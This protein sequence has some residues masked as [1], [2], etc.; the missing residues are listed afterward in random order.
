[1]LAKRK[2]VIVAF[3]L[4][5]GVVL[6]VGTRESEVDAHRRALH[7]FQVEQSLWGQL[8][9]EA[10][11]WL[12]I[13]R[14]IANLRQRRKSEEV[15]RDQEFHQSNLVRLGYFQVV[16]LSVPTNEFRAFSAAAMSNRWACN[17]WSFSSST[18]DVV[19]L[20]AF[21]GDIPRWKRL[22]ESYEGGS[23]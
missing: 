16:D 15:Q 1:M 23:E 12:R 19:H 17:L 4:V 10:P 9:P 14:W 3:A 22:A 20:T 13:E 8:P 2:I 5:L 7:R 21:G 6:F 18:S 11:N